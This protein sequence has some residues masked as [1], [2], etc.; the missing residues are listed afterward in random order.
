M[1]T[2]TSTT[3]TTNSNSKKRGDDNGHNGSVNGNGKHEAEPVTVKVRDGIAV[4]TF[5]VPNERQNTLS[6]KSSHALKLAFERLDNDA[7]VQGAVLISG[8]P[9]F[10]AGADVAM[11]QQC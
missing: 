10:I 9:D 1:T 8:K 7:S 5:D 3:A 2:Q 11:L 4:I 6:E